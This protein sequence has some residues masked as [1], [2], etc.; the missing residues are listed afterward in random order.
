VVESGKASPGKSAVC[1]VG[2]FARYSGLPF[3]IHAAD[4]VL[5]VRA[6]CAT[7]VPTDAAKAI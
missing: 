6:N 3:H 2:R 5:W 4:P 1:F 7:I